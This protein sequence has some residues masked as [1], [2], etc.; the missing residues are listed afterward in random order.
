MESLTSYCR[1]IPATTTIIICSPFTLQGLTGIQP[2][3]SKTPRG[4]GTISS[5]GEAACISRYALG[6]SYLADKNYRH[7]QFEIPVPSGPG[8]VSTSCIA[9]RKGLNCTLKMAQPSSRSLKIRQQTCK[10]L[11]NPNCTRITT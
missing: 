10:L 8:A 11:A 4:G 3:Q 2:R 5:L 1:S 6:C 9:E 7:R